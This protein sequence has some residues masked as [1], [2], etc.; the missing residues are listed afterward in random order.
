MKT[1]ATYKYLNNK[2]LVV[3]GD[4]NTKDH[5]R[6]NVEND[7]VKEA[8]IAKDLNNVNHPLRIRKN[9]ISLYN[10]EHPRHIR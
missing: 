2:S 4:E 10:L 1:L 7:I 9:N 6:T 8:S 5:F 3:C